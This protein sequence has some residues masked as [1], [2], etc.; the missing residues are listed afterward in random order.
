MIDFV[1]DKDASALWEIH[2]KATEGL[3]GTNAPPTTTRR[4]AAKF[5]I[6]GSNLL[7]H[8][9]PFATNW[10]LFFSDNKIASISSKTNHLAPVEVNSPKGDETYCSNPICRSF[11]GIDR[12]GC[13]Y[14]FDLT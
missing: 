8:S 3:E 12:V 1:K 9:K 4:W 14:R 11:V 6:V 13:P 10:E 7:D 2:E 5:A